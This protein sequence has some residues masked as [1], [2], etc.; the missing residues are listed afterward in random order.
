MNVIKYS[1]TSANSDLVNQILHS[2]DAI[3]PFLELLQHGADPVG[4]E[5][6][7]GHPSDGHVLADLID[8]AP[9]QL[10][11]HCLHDHQL[12][13]VKGNPTYGRQLL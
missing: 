2:L 5:D 1:Q 12:D 3:F 6:F 10:Q 11:S 7:G 13:M 4:L 9:H 8:G